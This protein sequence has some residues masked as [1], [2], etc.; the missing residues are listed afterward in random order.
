MFIRRHIPHTNK[1][2]LALV[3][4]SN[5]RSLRELIPPIPTHVLRDRCMP[6]S[7]LQSS[8]SSPPT[9]HLRPL[10]FPFALNEP[11]NYARNIADYTPTGRQN[12][13]FAGDLPSWEYLP[14]G[15]YTLT[16]NRKC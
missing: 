9:E 10:P 16:L 13:R 1:A 4:G 3:I 8:D 15:I 11:I 2:V 7:H 14:L 5:L 6:R 12:A